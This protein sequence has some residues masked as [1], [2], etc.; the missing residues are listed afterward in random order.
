MRYDYFIFVCFRKV[1]TPLFDRNKTL[2]EI[3]LKGMAKKSLDR[4]LKLMT[5][6]MVYAEICARG[7]V[8]IYYKATDIN[9]QNLA[10]TGVMVIVVYTVIVI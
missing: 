9:M 4:Q 3:L 10:F 1:A 7:N 6:V 5:L 8:P 2:F